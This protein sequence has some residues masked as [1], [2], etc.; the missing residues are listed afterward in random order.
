[1]TPNR[2]SP[3]GMSPKRMSPAEIASCYRTSRALQRYLDGEVDD[4]TAARV[5]RHL[6]RC[7]RCGL[8]ARTYRAIQQALR[9]GSRDVDELALRRLRAFTRSL[10]EPD[11]G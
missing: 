6:Q 5:A 11:D 10:A 2:R 4:P 8:R 9:S 7:R 1:M 3:D